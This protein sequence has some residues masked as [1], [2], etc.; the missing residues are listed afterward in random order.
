MQS[1]RLFGLCALR[2]FKV[3]TMA[4]LLELVRAVID[5]GLSSPCIEEISKIAPFLVC[6]KCARCAG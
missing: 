2:S 4:F 5:L 6:A 1:D 3:V